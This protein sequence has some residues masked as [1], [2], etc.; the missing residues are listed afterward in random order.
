MLSIN[1]Q[2][3]DV[4]VTEYAWFLRC[5]AQA[6][7]SFI[8]ELDEILK[9]NHTNFV[10]IAADYHHEKSCLAYFSIYGYLI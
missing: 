10:R 9:L 1:K 4:S 7:L 6:R 2:I 5:F 3:N 8:I